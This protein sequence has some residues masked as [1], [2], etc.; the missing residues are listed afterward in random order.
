MN[1]ERSISY[2]EINHPCLK[3]TPPNEPWVA[4]EPARHQKQKKILQH[5]WIRYQRRNPSSS[6]QDYLLLV[7]WAAPPCC[8]VPNTCCK[9]KDSAIPCHNLDFK[10][11]S[12]QVARGGVL[13][14]QETPQ[15][16]CDPSNP[17]TPPPTAMHAGERAGET[18]HD[19]LSPC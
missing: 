14:Q 11:R 3:R 1:F 7:P 19:A 16:L 6:I 10:G 5:L 15:R 9:R 12:K 13:Q 2:F 8:S 4:Q 17:P 18:S